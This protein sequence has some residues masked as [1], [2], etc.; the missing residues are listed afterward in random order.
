MC[1]S[2]L[3][4]RMA[5]KWIADK[6]VPGLGVLTLPSGVATWYV[7]FRLP[8]GRQITHRIGR[9][10]IINATI[11]RELALQTLASASKGEFQIK[12]RNATTIDSLLARIKREH[13]PRLRPNTLRQQETLWRVHVLPEFGKC[14]V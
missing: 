12:A 3:G 6:R 8:G 14:R 11:A 2:D 9:V 1:S 5:G 4:A 10:S 13:W 7:R